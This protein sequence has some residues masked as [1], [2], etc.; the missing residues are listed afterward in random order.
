MEN[1]TLILGIHSADPPSTAFSTSELKPH[2]VY[3]LRVGKLLFPSPSAGE[4]KSIY[5]GVKTDA[6]DVRILHMTKNMCGHDFYFPVA[7]IPLAWCNGLYMNTGEYAICTTEAAIT[8][9]EV[10]GSYLHCGHLQYVPYVPTKHWALELDESPD[11]VPTPAIVR[12]HNAQ[13]ARRTMQVK[14]VIAAVAAF[15][16]VYL[17][18]VYGIR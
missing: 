10:L 6:G 11:P 14:G 5:L 16:I 2:T 18:V 7:S 17:T 4:P 3:V 9:F 1:E 8:T 12:E 13:Q 15:A